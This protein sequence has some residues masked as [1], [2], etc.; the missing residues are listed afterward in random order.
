M[1]PLPTQKSKQIL[2]LQLQ[3]TAVAVSVGS[4]VDVDVVLVDDGGVVPI[5]G[6]VPTACPCI[7]HDLSLLNHTLQHALAYDMFYSTPLHGK[8]SWCLPF[9]WCLSCY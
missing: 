6:A 1:L 8:L 9:H 7:Q 3:I 4:V 2:L 5:V